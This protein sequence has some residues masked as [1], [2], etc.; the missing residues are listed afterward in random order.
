MKS[1][2]ITRNKTQNIVF[3]HHDNFIKT[4]FFHE[5]KYRHFSVV[6]PKNFVELK[7][8]GQTRTSAVVAIDY[9]LELTMENKSTS[10]SDL[11][12]LVKSGLNQTEEDTKPIVKSKNYNALRHRNVGCIKFLI[13]LKKIYNFHK[14]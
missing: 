10:A 8:D 1:S 14:M 13:F 3:H 12:N 6:V 9:E 2:F 5:D 4:T 11:S 7:K